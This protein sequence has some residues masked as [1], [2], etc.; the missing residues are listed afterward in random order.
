VTVTHMK[1]DFDSERWVM[2][3]VSFMYMM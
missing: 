3:R 2:G 1:I